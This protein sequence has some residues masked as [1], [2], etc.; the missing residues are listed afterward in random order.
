[1]EYVG[2]MASDAAAEL[3]NRSSYEEE[4]D[5]EEEGMDQEQV[6]PSNLPLAS[7]LEGQIDRQGARS[8][9]P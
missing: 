3:R 7:A 1:M 2:R 6:L 8:G 5:D 4:E 9:L